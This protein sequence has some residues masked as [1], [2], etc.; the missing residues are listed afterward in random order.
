MASIDKHL[1]TKERILQ[2]A[3]EEFSD[4]GFDGARMGAIAKR[5]S[6]NQALLHYY[7][8]TKEKL[9]EEVLHHYYFLED[10]QLIRKE[11]EGWSLSPEETLYMGIYLL[12]NLPLGAF[13]PDFIRIISREVAEGRNNLKNLMSKYFYPR[14]SSFVEVIQYGVDQGV[15]ETENTYMVIMQMVSFIIV[16][17]NQREIAKNLDF[18]WVEFLFSE[19]SKEQ[20]FQFLL[21][22]TFKGL[23]PVGKVV[24]IP[25]ISDEKM[26]QLDKIIA[27][28]GFLH[29]KR[30]KSGPDNA[31]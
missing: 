30:V 17:E 1:E 28:I 5:A 19:H 10:E 9:Y 3:K 24:K 12:V 21:K 6:A 26:Q 8:D 25:E 29:S 2:A 14:I 4:K 15:F 27:Q 16:Y 31:E 13:D 11:M 20:M 22:H 7:F 18:P 23:T